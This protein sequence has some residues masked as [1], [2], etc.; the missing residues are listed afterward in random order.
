LDE[1]E[2]DIGADFEEDILAFLEKAHE[3]VVLLTPG[4][5]IGPMYGLNWALHGDVESRSLAFFMDLRLGNSNPDGRF[6]SY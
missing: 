5:L 4:R 1:A 3:L 2:I 6:Q